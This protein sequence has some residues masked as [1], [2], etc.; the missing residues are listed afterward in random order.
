MNNFLSHDDIIYTNTRVKPYINNIYI[1]IA[2]YN[3]FFNGLISNFS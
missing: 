3:L 1:Y 2:A